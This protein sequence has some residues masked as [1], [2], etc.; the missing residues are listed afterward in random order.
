MEGSTNEFLEEDHDT[1]MREIGNVNLYNQGK[2]FLKK[3]GRNAEPLEISE[4]STGNK[5]HYEYGS[6][7]NHNKE[8]LQQEGHNNSRRR[9]SNKINSNKELARALELENLEDKYQNHL[10]EKPKV[11]NPNVRYS[12]RE[13]IIHSSLSN[14]RNNGGSAR[15]YLNKPRRNENEVEHNLKR[16]NSKKQGSKR[17]DSKSNWSKQ[18]IQS[19]LEKL[20][21]ELEEDNLDFN[22]I[23]PTHYSQNQHKMNKRSSLK[24]VRGQAQKRRSSR[25]K[26]AIN[27]MTA[28][29]EMFL[30]PHRRIGSGK[31]STSRVNSRKLNTHHRRISSNIDDLSSYREYKQKHSKGNPKNFNNDQYISSST[32][33]GSKMNTEVGNFNRVSNV[34]SQRDRL[35]ALK[36]TREI[37]QGSIE[38]NKVR[39]SYEQNFIPEKSIEWGKRRIRAEEVLGEDSSDEDFEEMAR[40]NP[41]MHFDYRNMNPNGH[42]RLPF[43]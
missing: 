24:E 8:Q 6:P 32:F 3:D 7:L 35:R 9:M 21:E 33:K 29:N 19:E 31:Q 28:Q 43:D 15:T 4:Y 1:P 41:K 18:R 2:V 16:R 26:K 22:T 40:P 38:F 23:K 42:M 20:E 27:E 34:R 39:Q 30:N 37:R 17:S 11:K 25:A 10:Y 36:S 14:N 13:M 5:K 12:E